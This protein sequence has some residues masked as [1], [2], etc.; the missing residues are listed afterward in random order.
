MYQKGLLSQ[1]RE[2]E[3][4]TRSKNL[5][6]VRYLTSL[7][8]RQNISSKLSALLL[9]WESGLV[10]TETGFCCVVT[11]LHHCVRHARVLSLKR[12]CRNSALKGK[13]KKLHATPLTP[14]NLFLSSFFTL[15]PVCFCFSSPPLLRLL[16]CASC[17]CELWSTFKSQFTLSN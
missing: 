10:W 16:L 7:I 13:Y 5:F 6:E 1:G 3:L 11:R 14:C 15:S 9:I 17:P 12:N 2:I 4:I 8:K